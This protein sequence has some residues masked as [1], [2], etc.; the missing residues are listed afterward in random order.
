MSYLENYEKWLASDSLSAEEKAELKAISGDDREIRE[1]FS[2]GLNFGTGGLRGMMKTGM[3]AMN[4]HTV[5]QAT[6]GLANHILRCKK[7][8]GGV[9]V[10]RDSRINS[11]LFAKTV[12]RVLAAN[13]IKVYMFRDIQPTPELSFA[14]RQLGCTA[15]VNI[16]ASHNPKEYNGY[17]AY[18]EDGAQLSL[19][20]ADSVKAEIDATDIFADV[21]YTDFD[22]AVKEELITFL[23]EDMD[24][25][26]LAAVRA[27]A[28][29]PGV[30]S[31]DADNLKIVYSPLHGT[32]YKLVPELLRRLGLKNFY[33]V[34]E[35]AKPDGTF[36]TVKKPNPEYLETDLVLP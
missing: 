12:A 1:R 2:F 15:G 11:E 4:V 9:V 6:Q 22:A 17:K 32:G 31:A 21:K 26:Y 33:V 10:G 25:A 8:N 14:L 16:T 36:P 29:N 24:E 20:D 3:N 30:I 19:E 27:E 18:W 13:G 35:Q 7:A 28:V 5:A 23:G 34:P